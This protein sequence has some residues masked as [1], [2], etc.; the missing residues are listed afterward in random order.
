MKKDRLTQEEVNAVYAKGSAAVWQVI[1]Q[2]Q[3]RMHELER[4]LGLNSSNSSKP[5]ST[6]L[7]K[8]KKNNSREKGNR[9]P[10]GQQGHEGKTLNQVEDP[11]H[12]VSH[13]PDG[14]DCGHQFTGTEKVLGTERRQ[15]VDIPR[16]QVK[17]TEYQA[18]TYQC[19]SCGQI[20]S[21][22]FPDEVKA[23]VQYGSNLQAYVVYL[24][25]YQLLPYKRTADLLKNL[26]NLP[27]SEGTLRNILSRFANLVKTP[28]E[29]I[30]QEIINSE[31]A[32]FDESGFYCEGDRNWLHVA[33]TELLTFYFHHISRGLDAVRDA[34]ILPKFKGTACHDFW[35]TYYHFMECEHSLCNAHH[36]RDLQ[37]IVDSAGFNWPG[38]MKAFLK[39]TKKTVDNAKAG[40]MSKLSRKTIKK[41]EAE[42]Q[43]IIDKGYKEIPPP[44][45]RKPGQRGKLKKGKVRN[46]LERLDHRRAEVLDF[47]YDFNKPFDNN[48]AERDI[49]MMK[50]KQKISGTFRSA[51]M[52]QGF[53]TIRS[54]LSTAIK[55]GLNVFDTIADG[56]QGKF[57]VFE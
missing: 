24:M 45:E 8:K 25:N 35:K 32:H 47:A 37:G 51:D 28:V 49:R 6:D 17:I 55:Q 57:F 11:D 27:I 22:T 4:R 42:Y 54:Y 29:V 3:D 20:H 10:G 31:V 36:L 46:L 30:K 52:A 40:N 19:P 34:D 15:V 50:V 18:V 23:P 5:P 38:E 39:E 2:L 9:K 53:C 56:F 7:D 14:C 26:H 41:L 44:P 13:E 16:P 1:D 12:I 33:S 21:G 48:Q 43:S